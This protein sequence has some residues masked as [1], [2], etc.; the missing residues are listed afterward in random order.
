M[1]RLFCRLLFFPVLLV[2]TA[3]C[4]RCL[5][6]APVVDTVENSATGTATAATSAAAAAAVATCCAATIYSTTT[7]INGK[8]SCCTAAATTT[9]GI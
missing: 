9:V 5:L 2:F 8:F 4:C 3:E 7:S 1:Y 6:S